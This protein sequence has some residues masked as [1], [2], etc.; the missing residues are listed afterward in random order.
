MIVPT[1]AIVPHLPKIQFAK[2]WKTTRHSR[3]RTVVIIDWRLRTINV[4]KIHHTELTSVPT[5]VY[6][7]HATR[8]VVAPGALKTDII[9]C[10]NYYGQDIADAMLAYDTSI[11]T[12]LLAN[13]G[14]NNDS[15]RWAMQGLN[16]ALSDV[17]N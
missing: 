14:D 6:N 9:D 7:G 4:D 1:Y 17:N 15:Q 8:M 13:F 12:G 16:W 11:H 10:I 3:E 2:S 5:D